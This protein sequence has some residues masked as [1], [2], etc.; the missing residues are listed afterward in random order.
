VR[1]LGGRAEW[2]D[3]HKLR[4]FATVAEYEHFTQAASALGISQPA[5]SVH[6]RDL[7]RHF[8]VPLFERVGRNV[9]LTD[10]GR[11][12]HGY[13]RRILALAVELDEAIADLRG[14]RT[15]HLRIGASTT[16]GEYLLPAVLGAFRQQYPGI[17]V[18][19]EIANSARVADRLRH[20]ELHLAL[21]GEPLEDA[22]LSLEAYRDD[23]LVLIVP[24]SHEWAGRVI[25]RAE[26]RVVQL[27]AREAGSAT[28]AVVEHALAAAG[29]AFDI[30]LE[31]GGTEAVK[32]AVA[33]G[34][35]VAFVSAC[36]VE[37]ELASGRLAQ[38]G[39]RGLTIQRQFQVARQR[40]RRLT[41]PEGAF[42]AFLQ[43]GR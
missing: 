22:A 28:R 12:A 39:V 24:H 10:A 8:G 29:V 11:V 1:D 17:A 36:T 27:I 41:A 19:V 23:V 37:Q 43:A 7:E 38:V 32:R 33:A 2:L 18:A 6:V 14:L 13:A 35:G 20:G 30:V 5:L 16:V 9:R 4:V 15:G 42:L 3:L 31:L 34:L 40:G 21:I 25:D 26:L